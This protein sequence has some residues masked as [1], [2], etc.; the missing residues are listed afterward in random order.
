[1]PPQ[2][3]ILEFDE[4]PRCAPP[5]SACADEDELAVTVRLDSRSSQ[6]LPRSP[7]APKQS[8]S[9]TSF[10][11]FTLFQQFHVE[12]EE[13]IQFEWRAWIMQNE[14]KS[15]VGLCLCLVW[16]RLLFQALQ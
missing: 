6:C 12:E 8:A 3:W 11:V 15:K 9:T 10:H 5:I 7:S 13:E 16:F 14:R 1:M 4:A 2:N